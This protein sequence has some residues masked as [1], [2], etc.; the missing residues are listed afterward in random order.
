MFEYSKNI[1]RDKKFLGKLNSI[2]IICS[3]ITL[4]FCLK[5]VGNISVFIDIL[6]IQREIC[7]GFFK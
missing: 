1:L 5:I 4:H 7:Y 3:K 6:D 2:Y